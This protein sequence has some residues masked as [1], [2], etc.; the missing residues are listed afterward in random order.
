[1]TI[2]VVKPF[3]FRCPTCGAERTQVCVEGLIPLELDA[4]CRLAHAI[5]DITDSDSYAVVERTSL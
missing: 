4:A 3:N 2:P 1:M 5:L